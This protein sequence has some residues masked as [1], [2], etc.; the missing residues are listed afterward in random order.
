MFNIVEK[1]QKAVKAI[2]IIVTA[3]FVFWGLGS[4]IGM[5]SD[6]G[7]VAKIG[8]QKIYERN[9]DNVMQQNKQYTDKMQVLYNLI[10]R[11]LILNNAHSY[12]LNPTTEQLQKEIA[13]IPA[14]QESG[15]FSLDKYQE[16][17][18]NNNLSASQ[19]QNDVAE[20]ILIDQTLNVFKNSYF[21]STSFNNNFAQLL[22][23]E[24]NV[25][26]Y[27]I[28][29]KQFYSQVK[30][31]PQEVNNYYQQ[32]IAKFTVPEQ[33]K[34]SYINLSPETIN[35]SNPASDSQI[36][37]YI[38]N[39]RQE[40]A[41]VQVDVSHILF[42]VP[43]NAD[44]ATKQKIATQASKILAEVKANPSKFAQYAKQY[45]QD[46]GSATKGGNL[47]YFGH[48][49][50][51]P[52]FEK[53]A[54]SLQPNQISNLVETKFGYHILKLNA[55]KEAT[56]EQI[57]QAAIKAMQKQQMPAIINKKLELL[58][59]LTYNKPDSLDPAAKALG[60]T[61]QS[62]SWINR[63]AVSGQFA[64]PKIQ[65]AI[66]S[67]EV[68]KRHNN[69]EV[70]D[71]G[72]NSYSVYRIISH[73]NAVVT[74][75]A[76]V[77]NQIIDSL[78]QQQSV[79]LANQKAQNT[80]MSLNQGKLNLNFVGSENV[81]LLSQTANINGNTVKQIFSTPISKLPAYTMAINQQNQVVIYRINKELLNNDLV[82]QNKNLVT[83]YN[84]N[85][86]MLDFGAYLTSLRSK[87]SVSYRTDRLT[88]KGQPAN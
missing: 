56:P 76:S 87:F 62:S 54:F 12:D 48:G 49:A 50:M 18:K 65:K 25:S 69:S 6:D 77:T 2:M 68:I 28:D 10:N 35:L 58:N 39:H 72:N 38:A 9:I 1:N 43:A 14:F 85:N 16:F 73:N 60:L 47:G 26:S 37:Q 45:S 55:K 63:N 15:I 67:D 30:P 71:L 7:Y 70:V 79:Q 8:D 4:Y 31:T 32:N 20:Q 84:A 44:L 24:R 61:I 34:V 21:N 78:K 3:S 64:N 88:N 82:A 75:V 53:V 83:Q 11:Q 74:P 27:T 41:N 33:V 5:S 13:Q 17:L 46:T 29:P 57:H 36:N 59:S 66:F 86:A 42:M 52:E 80:V 22:S 51:V 19:F 81:N 23:R 40:L